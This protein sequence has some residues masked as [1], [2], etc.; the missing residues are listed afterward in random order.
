MART[1]GESY[2]IS[3]LR[4]S[5]ITIVKDHTSDSSLILLESLIN[6]S[7]A[8]QLIFLQK[9]ISK[10]KDEFFDV[11]YF[12]ITAPSTAAIFA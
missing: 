9:D 4:I 11:T 2:G 1:A 6:T 12:G 10:E 8:V 3:P 7:G 5:A